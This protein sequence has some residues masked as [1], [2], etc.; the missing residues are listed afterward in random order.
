MAI[1]GQQEIVKVN[2]HVNCTSTV[3]SFSYSQA[4]H[5][6]R[7]PARAKRT[8][9]SITSISQEYMYSISILLGLAALQWSKGENGRKQG[10]VL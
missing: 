8:G 2:V 5:S 6:K 7:Y 4:L 9:Q 3:H 1:N 10:R